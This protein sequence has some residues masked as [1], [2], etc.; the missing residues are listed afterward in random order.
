MVIIAIIIVVGYYLFTKKSTPTLKAVTA[1]TLEGPLSTLVTATGVIQATETLDVGTQVSGIVSKVYVD[2]NSKVN[3]GDLL[4]ELDKENLTELLTQIQSQQ[5]IATTELNYQ[6]TI[7]MRHKE[8]YDSK[9][10]SLAEFQEAEFRYKN[11]ISHL[12]HRSAEVN[13]ARTNLG[14]ANIYSPID[15]VVLSKEISQGQTVAATFSTPTL[16]KIA[17]D[18]SKMQVEA[19]V[20]EADIAHVKK[21]QRITFMV[22][23]HPDEVFDGYVAQVRLYPSTNSNVV[24]YTCILNADNSKGLLM[25]GMTATINIHTK[26][27][28][29]VV[30]LENRA[31]TYKTELESLNMYLAEKY[32]S[33]LKIEKIPVIK[34]K[35]ER[36]VWVLKK[37]N[38]LPKRVT[39][40]ISDGI[41]T[42]IKKGLTVGDTVLVDIEKIKQNESAFKQALFNADDESDKKIRR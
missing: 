27:E 41:N 25:P 29:N 39:I 16:F 14:Y 42:Q 22:D 21:G 12:E 40:G 4:A 13:T 37:G 10:I 15:G 34:D 2:Y 30:M 6:K 35:N 33:A 17:K 32:P 11:A 24:T 20:D 38:I 5:Q 28:V 8:L 36:I 3:K 31:L 19:S 1:I 26:E 7:Y 18:L 9:L 23:A